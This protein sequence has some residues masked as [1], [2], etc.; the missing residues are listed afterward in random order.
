MLLFGIV[1][2]KSMCLSLSSKSLAR[3][4]NNK[5]KRLLTLFSLKVIRFW[6]LSDKSSIS[7]LK[8]AGVL[9]KVLRKVLRSASMSV[10]MSIF[11]C[12]LSYL[13]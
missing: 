12:L 1:W 8:L 11:I 13:I 3:L 2:K 10:A 5:I 4:A 6:I 7:N 9:R